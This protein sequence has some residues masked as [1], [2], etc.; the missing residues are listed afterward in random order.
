MTRAIYLLSPLPK[1]DTIALPMIKFSI[2]EDIIDFSLCDILIFTS[3][4]AVL[5]VDTID[6]SWQEYPCIA[7]G[8]ASKKQIEDLGGRVIYH[9]LSFYAKELAKDIVQLFY[10]KKLLYM[11]PKE[12]SFELKSFLDKEG[13]DL[14][15]QIVYETFCIEYHLDEKPAKTS[16]II[17][18][19]PSTV[20]CF[21]KNFSWDKSYTAI[22]IGEATKD[23][24]PKNAN[25]LVADNPLISSC[26]S[27]AKSIAK[28]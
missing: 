22:A 18:T 27:K 2:S 19:S 13:V 24:L 23:A 4:Q 16:I 6:A 1:K 17:F 28:V 26:I 7:I 3:K 11:R 20:D 9:P 12:V 14:Q 21:L 8:E 5:A 10:N 15:E 25:I